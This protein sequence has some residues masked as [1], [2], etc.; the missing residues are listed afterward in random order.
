MIGQLALIEQ[1]MDARTLAQLA[2]MELRARAI[3]EGHYSGQHRSPYRGASVEFADHR[4]YSHGDELRHL[5]WK[6]YGRSDRFF[7]KEYDA[8]TNLSVYLVV[9]SSGSMGYP[10]LTRRSG[11]QPDKLACASFLAAGLAYLAYRQRDA[12]GL[13]TFDTAVRDLLVPLTQRGHL[14]RVFEVLERLEPGGETDTAASLERVGALAKR[15]G[16]IVL[17]SDLLDEPEP[18]LRALQHFRHRGHDVIVFQVLDRSELDFDFRGPLVVQDLETSRRLATDA[19]E[20]RAEYVSAMADHLQLLGEGCRQHRIDH[21]V[22]LTDRPFGAAL[23]AYLARRRRT[24][25]RP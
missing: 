18:L 10:A 1:A 2:S 25:P 8:E 24:V 3:V 6:L 14:Q 7:V 23:T 11:F 19:G 13:M 22:F 12:V 20:I 16:L 4:Q 17:L 21:E 5:D 15:R 9:D